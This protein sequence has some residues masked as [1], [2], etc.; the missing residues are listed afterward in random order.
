MKG[1]NQRF[2]G[3]DRKGKRRDD[4]RR[5]RNVL[6]TSLCESC[7]DDLLIELNSRSGLVRK[8]WEDDA[9]PGNTS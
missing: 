4:S 6:S 1:P 5:S 8:A 2:E 9:C 3:T 7:L